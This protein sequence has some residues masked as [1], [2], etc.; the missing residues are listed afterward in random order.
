MEQQHDYLQRNLLSHF[1]RIVT[2]CCGFYFRR[3]S[4]PEAFWS[5]AAVW[6][7]NRR[8]PLCCLQDPTARWQLA[9]TNRR[10]GKYQ[11]HVDRGTCMFV[12]S[13]AP[14]HITHY[15]SCNPSQ[16]CLIQRKM[17]N[18]SCDRSRPL[19]SYRQSVNLLMNR[20]FDV[21]LLFMSWLSLLGR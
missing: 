1:F 2:Q 10:A 8:I 18:N 20:W 12:L 19:R 16:G 13:L 5:D 4:F 9:T 6:C 14:L 15:T 3:R 7:S 17:R 21:R 11:H